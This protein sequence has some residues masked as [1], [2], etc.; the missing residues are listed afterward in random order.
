MNKLYQKSEIWFAVIW[1]IIYVAGTSIADNL[2][3]SIGIEKS[4]SFLWLVLLCAVAAHWLVKNKLLQK[5]GLC[6]PAI[7]AAKC[8]FYI[9][10]LLLI[11]VNLWFGVTM[12]FSPAETAFYIGSMLCV[13]FIEEIIFRGF[14]FKAMS[15]DNLKTA[16][17]V[18]SLTFGI[19]HIVNLINGSGAELL[20][21]LCQVCYACAIGF[22]FVMI[23]LKTKSL[24]PCIITHSA[25]NALSAFSAEL[26]ATQQIGTALFLT[27]VP[28]LYAIYLIKTI[29]KTETE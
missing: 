6:R 10:L 11:S 26:T 5:Y 27:V 13:G 4:L 24:W 9:P 14:L 7:G 16:V 28:L 19:G 20:P 22:L 23:F 12:N 17:I 15:K 29:P 2:S 21:N 25:V 8:L 1:I 3:V 18:S